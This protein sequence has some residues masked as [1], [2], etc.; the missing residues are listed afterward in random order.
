MVELEASSKFGKL[1]WND[2]SVIHNTILILNI[3]QFEKN[4]QDDSISA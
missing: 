1:T 2:L 4:K 3:A